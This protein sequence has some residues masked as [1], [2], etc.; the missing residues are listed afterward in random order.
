MHHHRLLS[1]HEASQT[2]RHRDH[3]RVRHPGLNG[4]GGHIQR[5]EGCATAGVHRHTVPRLPANIFGDGL[6]V[7]H[8]GFGEGVTGDKSV[9]ISE[10]QAGIAYGIQR[11][12]NAELAGTFIGDNANVTLGHAD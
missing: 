11:D 8:D 7:I 9:D 5:H 2:V 3:N 1:R 6:C 10:C 4:G 12:L